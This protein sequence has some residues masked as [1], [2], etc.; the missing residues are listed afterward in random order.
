MPNIM[1]GIYII[2]VVSTHL[3]LIDFADPR[4]SR[5]NTYYN[6]AR[7]ILYQNML[8]CLDMTDPSDVEKL[9]EKG[10]IRSNE[11]GHEGDLE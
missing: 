8:A 11:H 6:A 3:A 9:Y 1:V 2:C 5:E 4:Q 10:L 7:E